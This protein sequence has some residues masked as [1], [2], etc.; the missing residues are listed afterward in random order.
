MILNRH[1]LTLPFAGIYISG[2]STGCLFLWFSSLITYI[3][4]RKTRQRDRYLEQMDESRSGYDSDHIRFGVRYLICILCNLLAT[5]Y[6][7]CTSHMVSLWV[8]IL[9]NGWLLGNS[10]IYIE[11]KEDILSKYYPQFQKCQD[12]VLTFENLFFLLIMPVYCWK[13]QGQRAMEGGLWT[14]V[15]L[16]L[17]MLLA[18]SNELVKTQ[19]ER[20]N[21][22]H[23]KAV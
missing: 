18:K 23:K 1:S 8:V 14:S 13:L 6:A 17:L 11:R 21:N 10:E 16:L 22:L 7:A 20:E 9:L 3:T 15:V 5:L 12:F 19:K 4:K 2:I